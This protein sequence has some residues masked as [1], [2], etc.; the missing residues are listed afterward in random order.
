MPKVEVKMRSVS[1][2]RG[3]RKSTPF[4]DTLDEMIRKSA[5]KKKLEED[6]EEL[7][8]E[9]WD[10]LTPHLQPEEK[11]VEYKGYR[12]TAYQGEPQERLDKEKLLKYIP[13]EKLKRCYTK[14]AKPRPTVQ[15]VRIV[16]KEE[17]EEE[18][19]IKKVSRALKFGTGR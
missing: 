17:A 19:T 1:E 7:R 13:A 9:V 8:M 5:M 15:V 12:I 6:L 14:G 3:L 16:D 10:A 4:Q 2:I 18:R 11:S